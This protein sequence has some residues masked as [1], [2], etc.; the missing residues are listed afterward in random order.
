[1]FRVQSIALT[2]LGSALIAPVTGHAGPDV[3]VNIGMYDRS[4]GS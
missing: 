2:L 1:M 3:T 4:I